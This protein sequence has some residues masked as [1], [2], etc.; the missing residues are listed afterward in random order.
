MSLYKNMRNLR[1]WLRLGTLISAVW[2]SAVGGV[3]WEPD[4]LPSLGRWLYPCASDADPLCLFETL[5][6]PRLTALATLPIF[7]AWLLALGVAWVRRGFS[8]A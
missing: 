1:G 7:G 5:S 2:L 4:L 8:G 6:F 3:A